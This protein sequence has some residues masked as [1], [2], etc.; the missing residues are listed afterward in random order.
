[1]YAVETRNSTG[2][3][4]PPQTLYKLLTGLLRHMRANHYHTPNFLD[5][6]NPLFNKLHNVIDNLFKQLRKEGVGS[7]SKH[8]EIIIKDEENQ[9]WA[10][11]VLGF[12]SP[13][14]LL[15]TVLLQWEQWE[16]ILYAWRPRPLPL[17]TAM[18]IYTLFEYFLA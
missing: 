14:A 11:N 9:L 10:A 17:H 16:E 6:K 2:D 1:M 8:T 15:Q 18:P 4:Y 13:T 7:E 3:P 12:V 5:K